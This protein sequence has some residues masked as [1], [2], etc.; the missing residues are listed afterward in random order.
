M[1]AE[2]WGAGWSRESLIENGGALAELG[3]GIVRVYAPV[4]PTRCSCDAGETCG[5]DNGKHPVGLEWQKQAE[6]D[7][8]RVRTMLGNPGNRSY[9]IIP[10]AGVFEWDVDKDAPELLRSLSEKLGPL[11]PTRAHRSGNGKHVFYRW[12]AN[13][14]HIGGNVFG[15]TTR[16]APVRGRR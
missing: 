4:S 2:A 16:W 11:P 5:R 10:P 3:F 1:T 13:V 6:H 15:V 9:G 14:R 8:K 7:P 12:P